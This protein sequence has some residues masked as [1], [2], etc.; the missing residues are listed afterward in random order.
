MNL[1][2][3]PEVLHKLDLMQRSLQVMT[4]PN[5]SVEAQI[6]GLLGEGCDMFGED[7]GILSRI[8]GNRFAVPGPGGARHQRQGRRRHL[9]ALGGERGRRFL[10]PEGSSLRPGPRQHDHPA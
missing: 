4:D 3:D 10:R 5:L 2:A 9:Q 6:D 1:K 8:D 7:I